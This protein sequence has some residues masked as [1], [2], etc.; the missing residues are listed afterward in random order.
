MNNDKDRALLS[1][2]SLSNLRNTLDAHATAT[3]NPI[4]YHL[5]NRDSLDM[6]RVNLTYI[7]HIPSAPGRNLPFFSR[8]LTAH[9]V[10]YEH[11]VV[12]DPNSVKMYVLHYCTLRAPL[13]NIQLR[14]CRSFVP[15]WAC[16][17]HSTLTDVSTT[18]HNRVEITC[19]IIYTSLGQNQVRMDLQQ[20]SNRSRDVSNLVSL[21]LKC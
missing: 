8:F 16:A 21:A 3:C 18:S 11:R 17:R 5:L 12:P 20:V 10:D 13:S 4:D 6:F 19:F 15:S 2:I 9:L 1:N 14:S 7:H